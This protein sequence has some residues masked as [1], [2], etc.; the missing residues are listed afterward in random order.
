MAKHASVSGKSPKARN[1]EKTHMQR[2]KQV[3]ET[4]VLSWAPA[5]LL[6]SDPG[7]GYQKDGGKN[8]KA[9]I[10]QRSHFQRGMELLPCLILRSG[11][12]INIQKATSHNSAFTQI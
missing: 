3:L 8:P 5:T 9:W 11:W 2:D 7:S 12:R 4:T 1:N 10:P 6:T